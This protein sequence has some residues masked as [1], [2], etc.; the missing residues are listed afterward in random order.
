MNLQTVGKVLPD[1]WPINNLRENE[2]RDS[3]YEGSPRN[4]FRRSIDGKVLIN[5][6]IP[7][8]HPSRNERR[9]KEE[10]DY[11]LLSLS[12]IETHIKI[13]QHIHMSTIK[14]TTIELHSLS[15]PVP[16]PVIPTP[17]STMSPP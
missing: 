16:Q 7:I 12:K 5:I 10:K 6:S 2:P 13:T 4:S 14:S 3:N 17:P 11:K 9:K 8:F 15:F 1:P